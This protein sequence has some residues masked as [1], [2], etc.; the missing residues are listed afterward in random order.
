[1]LILVM[2]VFFFSSRR[3]HTRW[4]RDWSSDV[5]SSDLAER[6]S[7]HT[8][9]RLYPARPVGMPY[10]SFYPMSKRRDQGQ[11]WYTL[12]LQERSKL[13]RSEERRVGKECRFLLMPYLYIMTVLFA[14]RLLGL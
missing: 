2:L 6:E 3:R 8:L 12:P 11:N 14:L 7:P 10:V 13:M 4:P 9:R 1:R 5:C